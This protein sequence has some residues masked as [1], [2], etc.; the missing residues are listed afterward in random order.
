MAIL[1][2]AYKNIEMD[3]YIRND[4]NVILIIHASC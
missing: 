3:V 4:A 2:R 1:F